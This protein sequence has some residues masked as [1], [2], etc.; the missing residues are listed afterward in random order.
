MLRYL[1]T[2]LI[3]SALLLHATGCGNSSTHPSAE[4]SSSGD[5]KAEHRPEQPVPFGPEAA[6]FVGKLSEA[7][8]CWIRGETVGDFTKRHPRI[9]VL[10]PTWLLG[11]PA[12]DRLIQYKVVKA[13]PVVEN[14]PPA[15]K[16]RY[17]LVVSL[18]ISERSA[19]VTETNRYIVQE[20]KDET[21]LIARQG[22]S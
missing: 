2:N 14:L 10:E 8:D 5:N 21:W 6:E 7:F 11:F 12:G 19:Q 18:N 17:E 22:N 20:N 16:R 15:V 3:V 9:K 13:R 1:A 4:V